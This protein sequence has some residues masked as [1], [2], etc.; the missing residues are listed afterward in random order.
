MN[1]E[2][3]LKACA[4]VAIYMFLN[5]NMWDWLTPSIREDQREVQAES[6]FH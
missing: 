4:A 1:R 2:V 3:L 5:K 6:M